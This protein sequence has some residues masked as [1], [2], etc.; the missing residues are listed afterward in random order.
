MKIKKIAQEHPDQRF[1]RLDKDA[2]I[3]II[4]EDYEIQSHGG[5]DNVVLRNDISD[6]Q[7]ISM[8]K[9]LCVEIAYGKI[10]DANISGVKIT[11]DGLSVADINIDRINWNHILHPEVE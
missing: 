9:E 3:E 5:F 7:K 10:Y 2:R 8:L 6:E 11:V 4:V 1:I